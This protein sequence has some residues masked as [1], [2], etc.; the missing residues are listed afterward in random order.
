[1]KYDAPFLVKR[2]APMIGRPE[3]PR[4]ITIAFQTYTLRAALEWCQDEQA[5]AARQGAGVWWSRAAV[6]YIERRGQPA[7]RRKAEGR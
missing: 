2:Y 6:L 7:T 4:R 1:M 5:H 3:S